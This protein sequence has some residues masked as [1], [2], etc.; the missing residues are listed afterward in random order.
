MTQEEQIFIEQ[1]YG[2]QAIDHGVTW[3]NIRGE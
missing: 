1:I 2:D 3:D